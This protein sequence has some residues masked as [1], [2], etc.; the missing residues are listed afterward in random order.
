MACRCGTLDDDGERMIICD[1]CGLW[2][3][4]RCNG[5]PE[6]DEEPPPFI[7]EGCKKLM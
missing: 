2:M 3:H 6:D 7:C 4:F 5:V 1:Y